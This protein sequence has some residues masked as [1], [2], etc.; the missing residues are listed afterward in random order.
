MAQ[1]RLVLIFVCVVLVAGNIPATAQSQSTEYDFKEQSIE[2]DRLLILGYVK[3]GDLNKAF[4]FACGLD[5]RR[6]ERYV[7][8]NEEMRRLAILDEQYEFLLDIDNYMYPGSSEYIH[9][10]YGNDRFPYNDSLFFILDSI[11]QTRLDSIRSSLRSKNMSNEDKELLGLM[12]RVMDKECRYREYSYPCE[13]IDERIAAYLQ[14][15][16]ESRFKKVIKERISHSF[17]FGFGLDIAGGVVQYTGGLATHFG[18]AFCWHVG[19]RFSINKYFLNITYTESPGRVKKQFNYKDTWF[20]N[21]RVFYKNPFLAM[22]YSLISESPILLYPFIG[23]GLRDFSGESIDYRLQ[24]TW[25]IGGDVM[26]QIPGTGEPHFQLGPHGHEY[27]I[28]YGFRFW[29]S[30]SFSNNRPYEM[31]GLALHLVITVGAY[32][33]SSETR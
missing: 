4:E 17:D 3:A 24:A 11:F 8:Y 5:L 16:P 30:N 29:V 10:D 1:R 22:G 9:M 7:I 25:V 20:E 23:L 12:L 15:Y 31:R 14:M 19:L 13:E 18:S 26:L 28:T 27:P 32:G 33:I 21:E 6:S 2:F